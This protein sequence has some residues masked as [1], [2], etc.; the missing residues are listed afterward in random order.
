[1]TPVYLCNYNCTQS[2]C[3]VINQCIWATTGHISRLH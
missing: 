2:Q 1:M 3:K